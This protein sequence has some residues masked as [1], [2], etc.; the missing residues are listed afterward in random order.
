[1]EITKLVFCTF[2]LMRTYFEEFKAKL[3]VRKLLVKS[4]PITHALII[5]LAK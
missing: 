4:V 2:L 3:E 5:Y 1:M